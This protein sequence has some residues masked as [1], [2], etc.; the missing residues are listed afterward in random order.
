MNR[1]KVSELYD[2]VIYNEEIRNIAQ[3]VKELADCLL[4]M[5]EAELHDFLDGYLDGD[6]LYIPK[7]QT[8]TG[9]PVIVNFVN[10]DEEK[11]KKAHI[12]LAENLFIGVNAKNDTDTE[13][14]ER[15]EKQIQ[16]WINDIY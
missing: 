11:I 8:V 12:I 9:T 14:L 15:K 13:Y 3:S 6:K 2:Y 4:G 10:D 16:E 7:E 1:Y 5:S